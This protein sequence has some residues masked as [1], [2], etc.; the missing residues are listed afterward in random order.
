VSEEI[1]RTI[2]MSSAMVA[3]S[4]LVIE[5]QRQWRYV[6]PAAGTVTIGRVAECEVKL[7]DPAASRK[8]AQLRVEASRWLVSDL[9][10]Y[11][12]TRVNGE[13]VFGER[14]LRAGDVIQ[15]CGAALAFQGPVAQALRPV[16]VDESTFHERIA[17]ELARSLRFHRSVTVAAVRLGGGEREVAAADL[18]RVLRAIDTIGADGDAGLLVLA[19]ELDPDEL[20]RLGERMIGVLG[21]PR[22]GVASSP[23]DGLDVAT[24]LATAR[25]AAAEASPGE[26]VTAGR[27]A[28]RLELG[29]LRIVLAEPAMVRLFALLERMAASDLPVLIQGETGVGKESAATAVH[30]YSKRSGSLVAINCAAI[31][32]GLVESELFGHEKGAFSGAIATKVGLLEA[33][34]AGTVF[35]DEIAE[36]SL[37][38]Q[39]KLLRA[40][41]TQRITRVGGVTERAIDARIV[42]ATHRDLAV[43]VRSGR[44]R[45]DLF[46]RLSGATV[47][48]PPLRDRP[49]ELPLLARELLDLARTRLGRE[50]VTISNAAMATLLQHRWPGNVRELRNAMEYAAA[51][52]EWEEVEPWDLPPAV[53]GEPAD[54]DD[55]A[56][57]TVPVEHRGGFRPIAEELR[58]LERKRMVQA[59]QASG[60]VQTR[61]AELLGMPRRTFVAKMKEYGLH[62]V[63]KRER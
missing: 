27:L 60:G 36:L 10:S 29:G 52:V 38:V 59:L 63:V 25:A 28:R 62:E 58:A 46:F 57:D 53:T 9:G 4:L 61:A 55:D 17:V 35:L 5:D 41:D 45:E 56:H 19:P 26:L 33:A 15:I 49:R 16:L 47:T 14:E 7:E 21:A 40:L 42:A 18:S 44:F 50:L 13:P 3:P 6:L 20:A 24:L 39:A 32:E 48:V 34:S 23:S 8:H 12:G 30:H 37:P 1:T 11:N 31:P 22:I 51:A 54:A 2:E 43:E